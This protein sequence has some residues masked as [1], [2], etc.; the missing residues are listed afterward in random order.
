MSDSKSG[1]GSGAEGAGGANG[2]SGGGFG[3][4]FG[5]IA[6][7]GAGVFLLGAT[8]AFGVIGASDRI[9]RAL[10]TMKQDNVIRVKG[11]AEA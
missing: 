8:L 10:L 11:V 3:R 4:V 7:P 5:W 6:T 1:T 9:G 2:S